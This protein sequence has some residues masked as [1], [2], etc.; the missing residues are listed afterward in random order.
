TLE[1][2]SES[3]LLVHVVDVSAADPGGQIVAVRAVLA[4]IGADQVPELLVFN[5]AD[6]D[7]EAA[8]ELV[9]EHDGSVAISALTGDGVRPMLVQ[10]GRRLR[11]LADVVELVV[12]NHRGDVLAGIHREGE[13][14]VETYGDFSVRLRARLDAAGQARFAEFTP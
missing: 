6:V 14:L 11:T 2:V 3:D 7:P 12:P 9:A 8:K 1:V 5:K 13:V 10:V 4:E